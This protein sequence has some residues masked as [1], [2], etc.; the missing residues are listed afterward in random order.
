LDLPKIRA[1]RRHRDLFGLAARLGILGVDRWQ[2]GSASQVV[3]RASLPDP[4]FP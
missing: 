3:R 2:A 4:L 1:A